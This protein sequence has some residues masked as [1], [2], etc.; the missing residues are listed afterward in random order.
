MDDG[1]HTDPT[2]ANILQAY[3]KIATESKT[4]D[5]AFLHYAGHGGK[6]RDNERDEA[7]GYDETLI[8]L[9]YSTAGQIRDDDLLKD[10]VM[11]FER[12]VFV[13]SIM[14]C[15]HS[16]TVLDLPY[17]FKADG[18]SSEMESDENYNF[19]KPGS[20]DCKCSCTIS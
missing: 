8:P 13:T 5:V 10:L 4:G 6:V 14:D 15:C 17:K 18:N 9:D 19:G 16:G 2:K 1:K 11:K 20:G 7:D 12:G 3:K